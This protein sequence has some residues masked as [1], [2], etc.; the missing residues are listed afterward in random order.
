M[1]DQSLFAVL[2]AAL[3]AFTFVVA[4][5]LLPDHSFAD[6]SVPRKRAA[7][8][9]P[10]AIGDTSFK[11]PADALDK[12]RR[13]RELTTRDFL[14][15]TTKF[16]S[17][18]IQVGSVQ[19]GLGVAETIPVAFDDGDH[20]AALESIAFALAEVGDGANYV[21]HRQN[22]RLSGVVQP[23]SSFK[24]STGEVCRVV[25]VTLASGRRS[26]TAEGVACRLQNGQWRLE[27]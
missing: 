25:V 16:G 12:P 20:Y 14:G 27:G 18:E 11:P 5:V 4:V 24:T 17:N 3:T 9:V 21:W 13:F 8:Q 2:A 23:T 7:R 22:G 19:Q 10:A 6:D 15:A 1:R 26:R